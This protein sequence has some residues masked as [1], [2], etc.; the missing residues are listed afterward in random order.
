[1]H[2]PAQD[3][4]DAVAALRRHWRVAAAIVAL[5]LLVTAGASRFGPPHYQATAQILLQQP[6]QVNAVLNPEAI[7]SAANV[8]REVNTNAQ[9]ITSIP[10]VDAVRRRLGLRESSRELI[11]RLS[12]A[13]EATSDLVE[14]TARDRRPERAAQVATEVATQYQAYRRRSAQDAI[15][16]A[17]S[18]AQM[19]LRALDPASRESAEGQALETRLHQLETGA[20]V[21]TGGVQVVRPAAVPAGAAPRLRPLVVGVALVLGLVLA[22]VAVALLER[23]DPRLLD[24]DA[25]VDAFGLPVIGRIPAGGGARRERERQE[26]FDALSARLRFAAPAL[27]AR[28]LMVAAAGPYAA[29]DIAIRLAEV[30]ADFELRVLVIDADLRRAY[31]ENALWLTAD[32][33]LTS[34][35]AGESTLADELILASCGEHGDDP[36]RRLTWQL[37]PAGL[38]SSRPT[39]L[40]ASSEMQALVAGARSAGGIVIIAAPPLTFGGDTLA[41]ASLCD[42]ILAVAR[43]RATTREHAGTV[44]EVLADAQAPVL[45]IVVD[46][47]ERGPRGPVRRG[48]EAVNAPALLEP[49]SVAPRDPIKPSTASA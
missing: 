31:S 7:T 43:P 32:G 14:I 44:R 25:I 40:L 36:D 30:L 41:L 28:V 3:M 20:A 13:G 27:N 22:A 33:G 35:L 39:A 34:V 42:E 47:G 37:L 5:T 46:L 45:G 49:V 2:T 9:L 24:E 15:G 10:V 12:V 38:G 18:A 4:G 29:D 1:M 11:A 26:A 19:R 48:R 8:Q 21:A 6:E 23:V 17:I 16:S